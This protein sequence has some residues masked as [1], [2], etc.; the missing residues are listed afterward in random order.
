MPKSASQT[1][2]TVVRCPN[3]GEDYSIT[4]RRCPFCDEKNDSSSRRS[5]ADDTV[6]FREEPD[7]DFD[8]FDDFEETPRRKGGKRLDTSA[9]GG[10][11]NWN[12]LRI[13]GTVICLLIILAAIW[14]VVTQIMPLVTGKQP[15]PSDVPSQ[16]PSA[17]IS[18][19]PASA[20][21]SAPPSDA[22]TGAPVIGGQSPVP[23][24]ST[25]PSTAPAPS[26]VPATSQ[27]ASAPTGFSLSRSDFTLSGAGDKWT[28]KA[29]FT[30]SGTSAYLSWKS[31]NTNVATVNESGTVTAVGKGTTNIV[32]TMDGGY[33][34]KCIVRVTEGD[35]GAAPSSSA[36]STNPTLNK[37][38]FTC[39]SAGEKVQMSVSGASGTPSWSIGNTGVA[40][41]SDSGLV[42]AVGPGDTQLTCTVDGKTLTCMVRCRF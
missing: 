6:D 41:V 16:Q 19:P 25:A 37:V 23:G 38:D 31:E 35:G 14:V 2:S 10:G 11:G 42:T 9:G 29:T 36:P 7:Y 3:C 17:A 40:T 39:Y 34:Q 13:I 33:S 21:P 12:P 20:L 18:V 4:Y 1:R 32:V 5:S 28:L 26:A 30:P 27:P 8:D 22:A 24:A 15:G